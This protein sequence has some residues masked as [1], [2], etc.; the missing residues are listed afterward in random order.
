VGRDGKKKKKKL[1]PH[2]EF[3]LCKEHIKTD[4]RVLRSRESREEMVCCFYS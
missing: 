3:T 4:K 1:R 2:H